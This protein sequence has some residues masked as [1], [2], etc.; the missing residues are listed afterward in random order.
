MKSFTL[1]DLDI[2]YADGDTESKADNFLDLFYTDNNKYEEIMAKHK[3]IIAGRKGTGK[4]ILSKYIQAIHNKGLSIVRYEKL[5]KMYIEEYIN[6]EKPDINVNDRIL[7]QDY[8][9]TLQLASN[10][11]NKNNRKKIRDFMGQYGKFK[12]I[13]RYFKYRKAVKKLKL[14]YNDIKPN[15]AFKDS[16][17]VSVKKYARCLNAQS[18]IIN[19]AING[20]LST[21]NSCQSKQ[22]TTTFFERQ[23]QLQGLVNE[24]L[25][26]I[27]IIIF[28]DDLDETRIVDKNHR[29]DFLISL[30]KKVN[31]IN[32][33]TDMVNS[34]SK[35]VLLLREDIIG[36]F[37]SR[38]PN[39]QKVLTDC[40]VELNWFSDFSGN[41]LS[42]MI[43]YKIKKSSHCFKD[44]S[45]SEIRKRL[46]IKKRAAGDPFEY[47]VKFGFGRPRDVITYLNN[48]KKIYGNEKTINMQ[49][50]RRSELSYS[51]DILAEITGE[52]TLT[53]R[54]EKI[55]DVFKLLREFGK[56]TFT[57][58]EL[59]TYYKSRAKRYMYID[60]TIET[61]LTYLY[62]L[63]IIGTF[64]EN[65]TKSNKVKYIYT[66]SFR[67]NAP[68]IPNFTEMI[69]IHYGLRKAL[70]IV[71]NITQQ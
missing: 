67:G 25:K 32:K 70:N 27:S 8:Y 20:E 54:C 17:R 29:I 51:K 5:N 49:M 63:G 43:M 15:G 28:I 33:Q 10:I 61:V 45:Y 21:E 66:W 6:L 16:E 46:F 11:V 65:Y 68:D 56:D 37:S 36:S 18:K 52:M 60:D 62:Y 64:R 9:L 47:I 71:D 3:F 30:I 14:Y 35:I 38:D 59:D 13:S 7:F 1:N 50:V 48:I 39:I 19:R 2:G 69:T 55:E 24:C 44:L 53:W 22:I 42:D 57:L 12:G 58:E 4:T 40:K 23:E 41:Q 26:S 34:K 31:D